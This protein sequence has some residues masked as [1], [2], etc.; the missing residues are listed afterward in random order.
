MLRSERLHWIFEPICAHD[1]LFR[2]TF[3]LSVIG[4]KLATSKFLT[5]EMFDIWQ[6]NV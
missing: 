1:G 5:V 4:P 3:S 2:L 6:R